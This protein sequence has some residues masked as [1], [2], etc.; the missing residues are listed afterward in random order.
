MNDLDRLLRETLAP[1]EPAAGFAARVMA[2][3]R[4]RRRRRGVRRMALAAGLA[5][6]L[7]AGG[8]VARR[9]A[10]ARQHAAAREAR[11][12]VLVALAIT[13][14]KVEIARRAIHQTLDHQTP[15]DAGAGR[16][17]A[18]RRDERSER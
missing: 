16:R 7:L 1:R 17:P 9:V 14:R 18:P 11:H 6:L 13:G 8:P 15:D 2:A 4:L 3:E 10:D 5:A 12:Q